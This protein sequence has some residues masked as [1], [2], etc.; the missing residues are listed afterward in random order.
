M[1][2]FAISLPMVLLSKD[3]M[4]VI[5]RSSYPDGRRW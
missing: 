2:S 4:A 1:G 5:G 3:V